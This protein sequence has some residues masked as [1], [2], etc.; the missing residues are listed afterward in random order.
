MHIYANLKSFNKFLKYRAD[1]LK[2]RRNTKYQLAKLVNRNQTH[3]L[4]YIACSQSVLTQ[5][6]KRGDGKQTYENLALPA[7]CFC[8]KIGKK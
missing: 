5:I 1:T 4:H 7:W 6:P 2:A 3:A 8:T